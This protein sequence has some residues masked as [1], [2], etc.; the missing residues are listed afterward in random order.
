MDE[1]TPISRHRSTIKEAEEEDKPMKM[2]QAVAVEELAPEAA[3][4]E[5]KVENIE[6]KAEPVQDKTLAVVAVDGTAVAVDDIVMAVEDKGVQETAPAQAPDEG[7]SPEAE[8]A[9]MPTEMP[10]SANAA[11][12]PTVEAATDPTTVPVGDPDVVEFEFTANKLTLA[13][14]LGLRILP[15]RK[16]LVVSGILDD[17]IIQRWNAS[18]EAKDTLK[19]VAYGT[20]LYQVNGVTGLMQAMLKTAAEATELTFKARRYKRY[21]VT[22][23]KTRGSLLGL[24]L[25]QG[26]VTVSHLA[27]P[28]TVKGKMVLEN[29]NKTC[30]E[31]K[32]I[33]AEDEVTEVN[34]LTGDA[35]ALLKALQ[36]AHGPTTITF[37]RA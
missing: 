1:S 22:V 3:P 35:T 33:L 32:E 19:V 17:G 18:D 7:T 27:E 37:V 9:M 5:D 8:P 25:K 34:G 20:V 28:G 23:N 31:G 16:N 15:D 26:T 29:Y 36:L 10:L 30:E 21:S 24:E 12:P 14:G 13:E 11:A 4:S 6:G 2:P